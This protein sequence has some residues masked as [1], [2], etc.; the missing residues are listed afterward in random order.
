MNKAIKAVII[1]I[2]SSATAVADDN[3]NMQTISSYD[4]KEFSDFL[5]KI[6]PKC[7]SSNSNLLT[8]D[9]VLAVEDI[10]ATLSGERNS[11][12][13]K[14]AGTNLDSYRKKIPTGFF[15]A[16]FYAC[17]NL[18]EK[19]KKFDSTPPLEQL[20]DDPMMSAYT[21]SVIHYI[22]ELKKAKSTG[23]Y[24]YFSRSMRALI[25]NYDGYRS[26]E[27]IQ[28]SKW[29]MTRTELINTI[30]NLRKQ[31][32]G[33]YSTDKVVGGK[34]AKV[35]YHFLNNRLTKISASFAVDGRYPESAINTFEDISTGLTSKYGNLINKDSDNDSYLSESLEEIGGIGRSVRAGRRSLSRVWNTDETNINMQM[36]RNETEL[37]H[38]LT[39]IS[40]AFS[41]MVAEAEERAMQSTL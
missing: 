18:K 10:L 28:G 27:V 7:Q 36:I 29:G 32:D 41:N 24:A 20:L 35:T 1:F 21:C 40:N 5:K 9:N 22:H 31:P 16:S 4:E 12:L 3:I 30:K 39:Y 25:S 13:E 8:C 37:E 11:L 2:L 33:N 14:T 17:Q 23:D 38:K 19:T 6:S 15:P 34:M 26:K